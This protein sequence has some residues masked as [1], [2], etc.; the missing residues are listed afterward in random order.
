MRNYSCFPVAAFQ[1]HIIQPNCWINLSESLV[2]AQNLL[3]LLN[4]VVTKIFTGESIFRTTNCSINTVGVHS[5]VNF[6]HCFARRLAYTAAKQCPP[7]GE[8][9]PV[10]MK[11]GWAGEPSCACVVVKVFVPIARKNT[12]MTFLISIKSIIKGMGGS[13]IWIKT[14]STILIAK[15]RPV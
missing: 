4:L 10:G 8:W 2:V 13:K 6:K 12:R 15:S 9:D 5:C 3:C 14:F 11:W 1:Y 7:Q